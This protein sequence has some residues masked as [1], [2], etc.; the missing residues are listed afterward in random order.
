MNRGLF[1]KVFEEAARCNPPRSVFYSNPALTPHSNYDLPTIS[2][3]ALYRFEWLELHS[4]NKNASVENA[5]F[6]DAHLRT[7][8]RNRNVVSNSMG[9]EFF[10]QNPSRSVF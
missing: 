5:K 10:V 1:D 7:F 8:H 6:K 4:R 3:L 2:D 9:Q